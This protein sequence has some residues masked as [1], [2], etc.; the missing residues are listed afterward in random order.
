M[1]DINSVVLSGRITADAQAKTFPNGGCI[2]SFS[3]ATNT[4]TKKG[5]QWED[6]PNFFEVK[7]SC[8]K[9]DFAMRLTKGTAITVQGILTQERW[10]KDGQKNSR[11]VVKADSLKIEFKNSGE[12][13]TPSEGYGTSIDGNSSDEFHSDIPF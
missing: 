2:I 11:V 8:K 4:S 5:E 1:K 7:Y 12:G 9:P 13:Y 6:Y 10:E 3:I